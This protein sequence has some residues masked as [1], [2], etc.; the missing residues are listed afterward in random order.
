MFHE[1]SGLALLSAN[2]FG[3]YGICRELAARKQIHSDWRVSWLLAFVGWGALLTFVIELS[4]ARKMLNAPVLIA[5]W[6][7]GSLILC[8]TAGWLG[9]AKRRAVQGGVDLLAQQH[10]PGLAPELAAGCQAHGDRLRSSR[11]RVGRDCG[12]HTDDK[13]GLADLS[14]AAG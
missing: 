11:I 1:L 4:S 3:I 10:R 14:S 2:W 7:A 13:P 12:R 8:G 5:A 6:L 9:L